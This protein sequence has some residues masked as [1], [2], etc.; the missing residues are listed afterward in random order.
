[1]KWGL[2][3]MIALQANVAIAQTPVPKYFLTS[4]QFDADGYRSLYALALVNSKQRINGQWI[5]WPWTVYVDGKAVALNSQAELVRYLQF[6]PDTPFGLFALTLNDFS[7]NGYRADVNA[8]TS[9]NVQVALVA[10]RFFNT[11]DN[12]WLKTVVKQFD[13]Q[14]PHVT[15]TTLKQTS[16]NLRQ[17]GTNS[18]LRQFGKQSNLNQLITRSATRYNVPRTLIKAVIRTESAF[19]R[20]AVS[21]DDARGLMQ[22]IP[23]TARSMGVNPKHLFNPAVAIDTGT[24]YLAM[25]LREFRSL[26]L[27]LAAYNA[28]PGAVKKYGN[29][30]PPYKETQAYVR[31]VKGFMRYYQNLEQRYGEI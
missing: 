25:Q 15:Y 14:M 5:A 4:A 29:K 11:Q 21:K 8:V 23:S 19:N 3:L 28:G 9:P 24:R 30:V 7:K 1:M 16:T 22:V 26:D 18:K 10:Q 6:A 31:K 12:Q 27:A 13:V 17:A 20:R 2:I